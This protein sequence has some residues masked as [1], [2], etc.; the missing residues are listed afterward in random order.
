[1][2]EALVIYQ[3]F[4]VNYNKIEALKVFLNSNEF[5]LPEGSKKHQNCVCKNRRRPL[6]SLATKYYI[7]CEH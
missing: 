5:I 6:L 7:Y 4:E 3:F 2:Y 1:M